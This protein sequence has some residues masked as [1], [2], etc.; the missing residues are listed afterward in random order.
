MR[1]FTWLLLMGLAMAAVWSGRLEVALAIGATKALLVGA[2]FMELRGAH[3][4]HLAAFGCGVIA[5]G[6]LLRF[7]AGP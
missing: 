4:A 7:I 5:L 6:L 1:L 2:Q 3:R